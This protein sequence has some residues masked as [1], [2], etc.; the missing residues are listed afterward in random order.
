LLTQTAPSNML[1]GRVV[2]PRGQA[3]WGFI[4]PIIS[5]DE[6]SIKHIPNAQ[7]V[8]VGDF[9]G[10]VAPTE[11]DAIKAAAELKVKWADPP[12]VLPGGG[13]VF[14]HL[15]ALVA[16]GKTVTLPDYYNVGQNVPPNVGC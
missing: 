8:R 4:A 13:N 5:V 10:V 6:S 2:R 3:A 15:R 7:I 14:A 12:A 16:A 11:W 9:L 1:H